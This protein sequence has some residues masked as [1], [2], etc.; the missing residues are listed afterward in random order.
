M[1]AWPWEVEQLPAVAEPQATPATTDVVT[2]LQRDFAYAMTHTAV[3]VHSSR[4]ELRMLVNTA[5]GQIVPRGECKFTD[6]ST[7]EF[8]DI[9]MPQ[10]DTPA[11][12]VKALVARVWQ[13]AQELGLDLEMHR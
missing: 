5:R 6:G 10:P 3:L 4:P 8:Q 9:G 7:V 2:L 1:T 13:L 12:E 11:M